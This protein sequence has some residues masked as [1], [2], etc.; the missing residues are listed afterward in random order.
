[1]DFNY[2]TTIYV[3]S[4]SL[5][6]WAEKRHSPRFFTMSKRVFQESL[7]EVT[8]H[9]R[10]ECMSSESEEGFPDI[11]AEEVDGES[12]TEQHMRELLYKLNGVSPG[13]CYL[14]S[15][16]ETAYKTFAELSLRGAPSLCIS[17]ERPD[18]LLK[19]YDIPRENIILLSSIS[20]EDFKVIDSLQDL[21]ITISLFLS[22]NRMSI[23]LLD[24]LEYL[25]SRSDFNAVFRFVQEMRFNFINSNSILLLPLDLLALTKK[26]RALLLSELTLK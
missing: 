21:S 4:T 10:S 19:N 13:E 2:I 8:K 22:K 20:V 15:S 24:G 23:V 5:K 12:T 18:R 9:K 6:M 14:H 7:R 1:M 26:E 16:H 17:R 11:V 3:N 25:I